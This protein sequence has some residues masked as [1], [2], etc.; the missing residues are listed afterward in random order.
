LLPEI[1]SNADGDDKQDCEINAS[2]RWLDKSHLIAQ[3]YKLVLL[4]DDLYSKTSLIKKTREK[5]HNYIFVCKE[6]SHKKLYEVVHM[7]DK[8]GNMDTLSTVKINKQR[9]KHTYNY[10]YLNEVDLTGD[11]NSIKVNWCGVEVKN[12]KGKITYSGAFITDTIITDKNI[13]EIVEAGRARWKIENE[14]NNTLK[15][16]GY[17][18]EHNFRHGKKGLSELLFVFNILAFLTHTLCLT[19]DD[20]YKELY[21]L[22][23]KRKTFFNHINTFTTFCYFSDWNNLYQTMIKGYI[24]GIHLY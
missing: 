4:G 20:D 15:T 24:D 17:N 21:G 13:Q 9:K 12:E 8:L 1:I 16:G 11:T 7:V 5:G 23:N 2:K 3:E 14:N 6:P 22:I 18:L 19:Y 10:K